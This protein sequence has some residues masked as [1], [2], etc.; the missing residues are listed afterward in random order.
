[1]FT[2]RARKKRREAFVLRF[3]LIV[4]ALVVAIVGRWFLP[5]LNFAGILRRAIVVALLAKRGCG[6]KHRKRKYRRHQ[7]H[8][9]NSF[10][11]L[12][13]C[14]P[15]PYISRRRRSGELR[16]LNSQQA[17]CQVW[18]FDA[19]EHKKVWPF[20]RHLTNFPRDFLK[21]RMIPVPGLSKISPCFAANRTVSCT[22]TGET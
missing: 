9:Q 8:H 1:M 11:F 18:F 2:C 16:C 3:L 4:V 10:E 21:D 15:P 6:I 12:H 20:L 22:L 14:L 17:R 7:T 13:N 19:R 5:F